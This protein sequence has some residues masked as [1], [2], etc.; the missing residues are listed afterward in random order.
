[1]N[2]PWCQAGNFLAYSTYHTIAKQTE[3]DTL[4]CPVQCIRLNKFLF[5]VNQMKRRLSMCHVMAN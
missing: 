3:T 1:M 4:D 5:Y 2:Q